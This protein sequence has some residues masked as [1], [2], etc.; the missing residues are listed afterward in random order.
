VLERAGDSD[1]GRRGDAGRFIHPIDAQPAKRG[2][3]ATSSAARSERC[4]IGGARIGKR[5]PD[6]QRLVGETV[7]VTGRVGEFRG[8]VQIEADSPDDFVSC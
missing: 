1:E 3:A 6:R 8:V 4:A 2:P 5:Y 7:A